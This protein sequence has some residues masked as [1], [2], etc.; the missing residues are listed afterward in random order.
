MRWDRHRCADTNIDPGAGI[1][2]MS[3]CYGGRPSGAA[4][5]SSK[6]NAVHNKPTHGRTHSR[7]SIC[8]LQLPKPL[9]TELLYSRL[10]CP[11][12]PTRLT[13]TNA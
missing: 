9:I 1:Y 6:T 4:R 8:R 11:L 13:G 5:Y 2:L 3:A 12:P 10:L 7:L